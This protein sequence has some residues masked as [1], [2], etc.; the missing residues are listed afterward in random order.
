[1]RVSQVLQAELSAA[2]SGLRTADEALARAQRG[3][4]EILHA[5]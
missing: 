5:A 1:V 3:I 2:V 4:E